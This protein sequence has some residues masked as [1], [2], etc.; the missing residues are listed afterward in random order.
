MQVSELRIQREKAHGKGQKDTKKDCERLDRNEKKQLESKHEYD[1]WVEQ[2][3]SAI[4][5]SIGQVRKQRYL[6]SAFTFVFLYI[7]FFFAMSRGLYQD[8]SDTNSKTTQY[9]FFFVL[10]LTSFLTS[11]FNSYL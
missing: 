6:S 11:C 1:M 4:R 10:P 7:F 2:V 3:M 5:V 9:M 8:S